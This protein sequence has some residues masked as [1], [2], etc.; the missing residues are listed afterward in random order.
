MSNLAQSKVCLIVGGRKGI[1]SALA[2]ILAKRASSLSTPFQIIKTSSH[3][4]STPHFD[5]TFHNLKLDIND[6][7]SVDQAA[8]W[9]EEN[10]GRL[11][12][13]INSIGVLHGTIP[14]NNEEKKFTPEKTAK[15]IDENWFYENI[16]LNTYPSILLAQKFC[17]IMSLGE[18]AENHAIFAAISAK[19]GSIQDNA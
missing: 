7:A 6:K 5:S 8:S 1:G 14:I 12:L 15:A 3:F 13:L 2:D 9:V 10:F 19:I 4:P 11:D 18:K 17:P 16:R